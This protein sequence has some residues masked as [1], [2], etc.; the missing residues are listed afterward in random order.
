MYKYIEY[1]NLIKFITNIRFI[2]NIKGYQGISMNIKGI[3]QTE[4]D[5]K[6]IQWDFKWYTKAYQRILRDFEEFYLEV[7]SVT[8][9]KT[10]IADISAILRDSLGF[11]GI[12]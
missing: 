11:Q 2:R 12:S 3:Q 10:I 5:F 1:I 8:S 9:R 6:G 4:R 7:Y